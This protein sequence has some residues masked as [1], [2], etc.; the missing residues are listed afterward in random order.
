MSRLAAY[1]REYRIR[2]LAR[3]NLMIDPRA[4]AVGASWGYQLGTDET[5]ATSLMTATSPKR[6]NLA[7][8]PRGTAASRWFGTFGTGGAGT[9]TMVSGAS[10]GPLLPD[11][12]QPTTYA[13]YTFTTANTGGNAIFGYN[14]A[15]PAADVYP[16]G[17]PAALAIYA[18]SSRAT[19]NTVRLYG[20]GLTS[21]GAG[22]DPSYSP[23]FSSAAAGEW[24]RVGMIH[25][26]TVA[27]GDW[28]PY[29]HFSNVLF[30]VGDTVDV[31]CVMI[32]PG[33]TEVGPHF[34]GDTPNT[35]GTTYAWT[36]S[37]NASTSTATFNDGPLLPDGSRVGTYVRRTVTALKTGG[38]SGPW[39]RVPNGSYSLLPGDQ[40]TPTMY[41]RFSVEVSATVQSSA[42]SG[43][44][45][46]SSAIETVTIPANTWTRIGQPVTATAAADNTQVWATLSSEAILPVGATVDTT[47]GLSEKVAQTLPYFDGD[48]PNSAWTG[49]ANA[50][51]STTRTNVLTA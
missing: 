22:V 29:A 17:T 20:R 39:C 18:R 51:T 37:A 11:G 8:D 27:V 10:D 49:A 30:Q 21:A 26:P 25:V 23:A 19:G 34:D 41:V 5:A 42:R 47:A 24:I 15:N 46:V 3:T 2:A 9:E 44:G 14:A 45:I 35:G 28:M 16:A 32:E 50:S 31:V 43:S 12:T 36:G 1:L 13:R 7:T 6:T 33:A 48:M 40:V 38:N 4:T